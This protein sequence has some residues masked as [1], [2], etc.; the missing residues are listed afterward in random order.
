MLCPFCHPGPGE[1]V[2]DESPEARVIC[3]ARPMCE[4]HVLIVPKRHAPSILDLDPEIY[5][6]IRAFQDR[7]M[8]R[9]RSML[10]KQG[11]MSTV[12]LPYA[13]SMLRIRVFCMPISTSYLCRQASFRLLTQPR[14][15]RAV[16]R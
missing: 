7:V 14:N 13:D 2:I 10:A 4:G 11:R 16:P 5:D 3:D 1:V 6:R 15:R 12:A 9:M 8:K